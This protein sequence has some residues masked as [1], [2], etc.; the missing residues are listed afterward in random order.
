MTK[1]CLKFAKI[2]FALRA[3]QTRR[4]G[5]AENNIINKDMSFLICPLLELFSSGAEIY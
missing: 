3:Q 5:G 4:G 2:L 1:S